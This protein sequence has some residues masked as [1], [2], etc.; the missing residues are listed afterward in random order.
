MKPR[1]SRS[2]QLTRAHAIETIRGA[3]ERGESVVFT[4]GCFDLLHVGHAQSLEEARTL[5]DRLI[6]ALNSDSSVRAL[7]GD[8]RPLVPLKQRMRL[9]ASL[10]CVDWVVS[11]RD[12]T[13]LS[14]IQDLKPD[15]IAKGGDWELDKIVGREAVESWGG[16]V[17]RL[18]EVEGIHTS[19][20]IQRIRK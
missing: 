4:N 14:L 20:L 11:F 1:D 5:G 10:E 2:K 12:R 9:V 8:R 15:V 18:T 3:R 19:Q 13:P 17:A 6:V 7:K 16:R